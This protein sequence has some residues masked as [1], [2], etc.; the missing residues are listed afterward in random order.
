MFKDYGRPDTV[1]KGAAG[2]RDSSIAVRNTAGGVKR[3]T[4]GLAAR[5]GISPETGNLDQLLIPVHR[6]YAFA[7][8]LICLRVASIKPE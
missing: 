2:Q 8:S 1:W 5:A 4:S 7:L 6:S 3:L